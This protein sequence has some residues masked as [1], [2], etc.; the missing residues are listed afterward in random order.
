MAGLKLYNQLEIKGATKGDLLEEIAA[1][2]ELLPQMVGNLYP[3]ILM[4][5]K[6]LMLNELASRKLKE[7]F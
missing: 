3:S 6:Q 2:D 4:E 5:K 1:I 7:D